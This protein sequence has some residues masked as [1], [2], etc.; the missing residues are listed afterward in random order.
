MRKTRF[1]RI[2]MGMKT[3]CFNKNHAWFKHYGGRGITVCKGWLDFEVFMGDMFESYQL[4]VK[5]FGEMNTSLDRI[6]SN[7]GYSKKNCKWATKLEQSNN[8]RNNIKVIFK[9]KE[10]TLYEWCEVLGMSYTKLW[11]RLFTLNMPIEMAFNKNHRSRR[12]KNY[13]K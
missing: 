10:K 11:Q 1:Y 9:G 7:I 6:N 3:R 8:A 5:N 12:P 4:H 2:W 13:K